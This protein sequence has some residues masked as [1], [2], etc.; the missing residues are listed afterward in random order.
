MIMI[1]THC[2]QVMMMVSSQ[3][4]L[5]SYGH[6]NMMIMILWRWWWC[7]VEGDDIMIQALLHASPDIIPGG[8]LGSK[9]QL[10]NKSCFMLYG[11]VG[12]SV[13]CCLPCVHFST[14]PLC[15][16][17]SVVPT[18]YRCG[19][20]L[21]CTSVVS[22]WYLCGTCLVCTSVVPTWYLC[23]ICLVCTSVVSTWYLCGICLVCTSVV[24]IWYFCGISLVS[25]TSVVSVLFVPL[26]Y[27]SGTSVVYVWYLCGICLVP[28]W[29]MSGTSVVSLWYLW[30][31][32]YLCGMCL[33]VLGT[34]MVPL[35]GQRCG[36]MILTPQWRSCTSSK[37]WNQIHSQEEKHI[38]LIL[39]W[40][41]CQLVVCSILSLNLCV[42]FN[43]CVLL[44]TFYG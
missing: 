22:T 36:W 6:S 40:G 35:P 37:K 15:T 21:V 17:T 14:H 33:L 18:W 29:Y 27:L 34:S 2:N 41:C 5:S 42:L 31:L 44:P 24:S 4:R 32:W 10:T 16:C 23:G 9:H 20:C 43:L 28:L 39:S 19:I 13:W 1:T 12:P 11:C 38:T 30:Y 8:W 7:H 26:W 3:L 25:G